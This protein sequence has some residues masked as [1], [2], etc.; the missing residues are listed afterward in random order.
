MPFIELSVIA[1][2]YNGE[3]AIDE[4]VS[5]IN[6]A[7]KKTVNSYEIILVEDCS[8]D[9]SW[10]KI[11]SICQRHSFV[12]GIQLSRNFGQQ[13][14]MSAGIRHASGNFVVIMDG[15]LQNPPE[16]IPLLIEKLK[17]DYDVVYT[18][19]NTRNNFKDELTS[20]TFY[21]IL[22]SLFK[23]GMIPN[24]L[25]LKGFSKRFVTTYNIYEERIRVV[26]G[27]VHDIGLNTTIIEVENQKRKHGKSN[28]NFF[29]R[30]YLMLD[31]IMA[32]TVK[33]LNYI[34]NISILA[35]AGTMIAAI[36]NLY[37]YFVK[38]DVPAGYT[39]IVLLILFFG[40]LIT[41]MLGIIGK[42]LSNIYTEVRNRPA[43]IVNKKINFN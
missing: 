7:C 2:I 39:T 38:Q 29:K 10:K 22:N 33:P 4:L 1:T 14:A 40:S 43:F 6:D 31:M 17:E 20:K 23:V 19:S 9:K 35:L 5:R 26:A 16:A 30:F 28:Y 12:K 3:P 24:Q 15:D 42:Y 34:I 27:I 41:F 32:M 36:Y 37:V 11:Q 8:K 13:M 21:F 25:M 18:V